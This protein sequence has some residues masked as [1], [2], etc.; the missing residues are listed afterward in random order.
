MKPFFKTCLSLGLGLSLLYGC[1]K[2]EEP[3]PATSPSPSTPA[4]TI[5]SVPTDGDFVLFVKNEQIYWT[6]DFVSTFLYNSSI[7]EVRRIWRSGDTLLFTIATDQA[8]ERLYYGS[9][10]KPQEFKY[11][12][13]DFF[14][15]Y[16]AGIINGVITGEGLKGGSH[17]RFYCNVKEGASA[18]VQL[19]ANPVLLN[20]FRHAGKSVI[21]GAFLETDT[22]FLYTLNGKNWIQRPMPTGTLPDLV[23]QTKSATVL[24]NFFYDKTYTTSDTSFQNWTERSNAFFIDSSGYMSGPF[25]YNQDILYRIGYYNTNATSYQKLVLFSK[26]VNDNTW[27]GTKITAAGFL[28]EP[29]HNKNIALALFTNNHSALIL[30]DFNTTDN[31]V[32]FSLWLSADHLNYTKSSLSSDA[33]NDYLINMYSAIKFD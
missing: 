10:H 17:Y 21:A 27:V 6:R 11:V 4:P 9:I 12:T 14:T 18:L 2:K 19:D 22:K 20:F 30:E 8:T 33:T 29:N 31:K 26:S 5:N 15:I 7:K 25:T 23:I 32:T 16:Q 13:S 24:G 3:A 28:S 1:K